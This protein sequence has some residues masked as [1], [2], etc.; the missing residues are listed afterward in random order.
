MATLAD[1]RFSIRGMSMLTAYVAFALWCSS[2]RE[3][4]A[5]LDEHNLGKPFTTIRLLAFWIALALV[6]WMVRTTSRRL[7]GYGFVF[8]GMLIAPLP[9]PTYQMAMIPDYP[10]YGHSFM[11]GV[12]ASLIFAGMMTGLIA[13]DRARAG[14]SEEASLPGR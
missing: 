8:I 1:W 2:I 4:R 12:A 5:A 9:M 7:V 3:V 11:L 14:N 10:G 13:R 6:A